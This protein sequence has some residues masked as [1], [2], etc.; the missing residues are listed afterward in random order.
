MS[1]MNTINLLPGEGSNVSL[2][3]FSTLA[4]KLRWTSI[5]VVHDEKLM[6]SNKEKMINLHYL[7]LL[8]EQD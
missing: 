6:L 5:L 7:N 1:S 4:S 3:T 8:F 2:V